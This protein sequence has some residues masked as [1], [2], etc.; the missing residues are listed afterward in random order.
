VTAAAA[1]MFTAIEAIEGAEL[2]ALFAAPD[3]GVKATVSHLAYSDMEAISRR[4]ADAGMAVT[5][6]A[7]LDDAG[8][9]VSDISIGARP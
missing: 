5:E 1:A 4:M 9:V 6:N 7:T 3:A 2:D 8:R